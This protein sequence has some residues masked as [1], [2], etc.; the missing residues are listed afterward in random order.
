MDTYTV[1]FNDGIKFEFKLEQIKSIPHFLSAI[2]RCPSYHSL[3]E[4]DKKVFIIPRSSIGFEFLH[5]YATSDEPDRFLRICG[6][7]ENY[8]AVIDQCDFFKYYKLRLLLEEKFGFGPLDTI[9]TKIKGD[10]MSVILNYMGAFCLEQVDYPILWENRNWSNWNP[11]K[12]KYLDVEC[13]TEDDISK[14]LYR[15]S[16][17]SESL[18]EKDG[19]IRDGKIQQF[20][21]YIQYY[22][23]TPI[24]EPATFSPDP[25][26]NEIYLKRHQKL[27]NIY[28][29]KLLCE[30]YET[31]N[32]IAKIRTGKTKMI[33]DPCHP[34]RP[35][36]VDEIVYELLQN[37]DPDD[38]SKIEVLYVPQLLTCRPEYM[39][40]ET[41]C[42]KIMHPHGI[43]CDWQNEYKFSGDGR[44]STR[45]SSIG[46]ILECCRTNQC[47]RYRKTIEIYKMGES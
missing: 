9:P 19:V 2:C 36:S 1:H 37:V 22:K 3:P 29:Y 35:K 44:S 15:F 28:F 33:P 43:I 32:F 42:E 41:S 18:Y 11:P 24:H 21:K 12:A 40:K 47:G 46:V 4:N 14:S 7:P 23:V 34:H 8:K 30:M 31:N 38:Y 13:C 10:T 25:E 27:E 45:Y 16:Q 20:G 39:L 26:I 5:L 17:L 6:L